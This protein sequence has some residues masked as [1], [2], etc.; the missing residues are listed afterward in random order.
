M[1]GL[2]LNF[3]AELP[4]TYISLCTGAQFCKD[5]PDN[6][7]A[8]SEFRETNDADLV[9]LPSDEVDFTEWIFPNSLWFPCS[10]IVTGW[11][12]RAE[13]VNI[14]TID[15]L[16]LW[17]IYTDFL[18]TPTNELDFIVKETTGSRDEL[19]ELSSGVY[20]YLLE[21]PVEVEV[22]DIVGITY[23]TISSDLSAT[24][25]PSFT[26]GQD[27]AESYRRPFTGLIFDASAIITEYDTQHFPVVTAIMGT[28]DIS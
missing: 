4:V 9:E 6:F 21:T 13:S 1:A 5:I 8:I 26:D 2:L 27:L 25:R 15:R 18:T 22:G 23:E 19:S 11:I 20:Q 17:R 12:F 14:D 28:G 16:P 3:H 10:G 24:L 7:T